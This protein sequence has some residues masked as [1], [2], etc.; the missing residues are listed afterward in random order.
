MYRAGL[1]SCTINVRRMSSSIQ[2]DDRLESPGLTRLRSPAESAWCTDVAV[3]YMSIGV[4]S[5]AGLQHV[6]KQRINFLASFK[7]G[8]PL[9]MSQVQAAR[10]AGVRQKCATAASSW[11]SAVLSGVGAEMRS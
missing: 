7:G 9:R 2:I 3:A 11:R 6:Q 4:G 8:G 1:T 10:S 5:A